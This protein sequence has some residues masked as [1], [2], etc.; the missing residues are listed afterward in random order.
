MMLHKLIQ[1]ARER[2]GLSLTEAAERLG[3]AKSTLSRL[4]NGQASIVASRLPLFAALYGTTVARILNN[5]LGNRPPEPD[6]AQVA[7]VVTLVQDVIRTLQA[8][9][10]PER[11]GAVVVELIKLTR[12]DFD[13]RLEGEFDPSRYR[14]IVQALLH[15]LSD[16]VVVS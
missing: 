15:N 8:S 2:S 7:V 12:D 13:Q 10:N 9:P 1:T 11:V 14:G 3:I 6:Y 4:E 5:D 16:G